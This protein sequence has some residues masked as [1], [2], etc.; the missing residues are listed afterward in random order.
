MRW[1]THM[2]E[3][4]RHLASEAQCD[5]DEVLVII[6]KCSRILDDIFAASSW[7]L[8]DSDFASRPERETLPP[9]VPIKALR[10]MLEEVRQQIR[11]GL[12]ENSWFPSMNFKVVDEPAD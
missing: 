1:T 3:C 6:T 8:S 5:N 2:E 4:L 7:A 10:G 9:T 11:P 12:L